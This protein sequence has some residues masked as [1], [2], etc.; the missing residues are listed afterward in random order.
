LDIV[1]VEIVFDK[2]EENLGGRGYQ[3]TPF[4]VYFYFSRNVCLYDIQNVEV[5][6]FEYKVGY[7]GV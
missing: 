2:E 1:K 7:V 6:A 5:V 4:F 3:N